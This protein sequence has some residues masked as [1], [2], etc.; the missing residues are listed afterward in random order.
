MA[1]SNALAVAALVIGLA[2]CAQGRDP[3][4]SHALAQEP[5]GA[6]VPTLGPDDGVP[7]L[8]S[9]AHAGREAQA[10]A[11]PAGGTVEE[12]AV[13]AGTRQPARR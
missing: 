10:G 1:P 9:S 5:P 3:T 13:P 8:P 7:F 11:V 4:T 6:P 12:S 2:S